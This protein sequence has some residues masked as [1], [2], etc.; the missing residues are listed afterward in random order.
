MSDRGALRQTVGPGC[1]G[2]G[3]GRLTPSLA[4]VPLVHGQGHVEAHEELVLGKEGGDFAHHCLVQASRRHKRVESL[5]KLLLH[6][7][8]GLLFGSLGFGRVGLASFFGALR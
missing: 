8:V 2:D 1:Q 5:V 3:R 7:A 4:E 6:G